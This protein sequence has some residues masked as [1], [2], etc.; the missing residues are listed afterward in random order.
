VRK[1][2]KVF[3]HITKKKRERGKGGGK[4]KERELDTVEG[5]NLNRFLEKLGITAHTPCQ[6][7]PEGVDH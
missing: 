6:S 5:V 4:G 2:C 3:I 1:A 7:P